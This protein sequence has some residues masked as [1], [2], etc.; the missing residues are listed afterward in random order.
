[1]KANIN[2]QPGIIIDNQTYYPP[3]WMWIL[4]FA[5]KG[6]PWAIQEMESGVHDAAMR[7]FHDSN[8]VAEGSHI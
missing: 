6:I 7:Q 2:I 4:A 1:M 8:Y 3:G 5:L